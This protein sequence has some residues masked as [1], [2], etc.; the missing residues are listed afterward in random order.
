MAGL[1]DEPMIVRTIGDTSYITGGFF[2]M[3]SGGED[4]WLQFDAADAT[5]ITADF[6]ANIGST[7]PLD[8]Y[9]NDEVIVDEVG[10]ET[11]D[12]VNTTHYLV[13]IVDDEAAPFDV[14][15][16]DEGLLRQIITS[17][18]QADDETGESVQVEFTIRFFDYGEPVTI[19]APPEDKVVDGSSM[20]S[21]LGGN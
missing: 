5:S 20:T 2:S 15:I 14:W 4:N 16:D 1:L 19:E 13:T 3:F 18:S 8:S 17:Q 9:E 10:T 7:S 11:I 6:G 12:G 21:L